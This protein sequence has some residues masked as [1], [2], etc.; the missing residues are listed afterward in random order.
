MKRL[1]EELKSRFDYIILDSAPIIPITDAGILGAQT[2]GIMFVVQAQK[3]QE[4]EIRRSQELLE[5]A[6]AKIIGFVLTQTDYYIPGYYSHYY[7]NNGGNGKKV[8]H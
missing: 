6:H 7:H 8:K 3:T 4:Q 2:D 5:Q 1:L